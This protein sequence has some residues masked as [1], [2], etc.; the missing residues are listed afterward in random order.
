M[1]RTC[2]M[3]DTLTP[4]ALRLV[5]VSFVLFCFRFR[6]AVVTKDELRLV[7]GVDETGTLQR[8]RDFC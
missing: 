7:R 5:R 6:S 4:S 3:W 2:H 1:A 8:P